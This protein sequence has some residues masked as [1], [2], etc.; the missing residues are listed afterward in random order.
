MPK[1]SAS[2]KLASNA[3]AVVRQ[4]AKAAKNIKASVKAAKKAVAK[5]TVKKKAPAKVRTPKGNPN[6][7]YEIRNAPYTAGRTVMQ[8]L[9]KLESNAASFDKLKAPGDKW[10]VKLFGHET[11]RTFNSAE[12]I[13]D[14]LTRRYEVVQEKGNVREDTSDDL[15]LMNNIQILSTGEGGAEHYHRR[16]AEKVERKELNKKRVST[17]RKMFGSRDDSGKLYNSLDY[18]EK[19]VEENRKLQDRLEALE[20]AMQNLPTRKSKKV[21]K[22]VTLTPQQKAAAT[23]KANKEAAALKAAARSESAKKAAKTR[24]KNAAAALKKAAARSKAA[25]KAAKTRKANRKGR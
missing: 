24:A 19:L 10:V 4:V 22:K 3:K 5:K 13:N 15:S 18:S 16:A 8:R 11:Y 7:I 20:K 23:R 12:Q 14:Y 6:G 9:S 25:K 17:L 21:S 2:K 1:K